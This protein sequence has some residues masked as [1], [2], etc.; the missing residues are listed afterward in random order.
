M[1]VNT[2]LRQVVLVR[3]CGQLRMYSPTSEPNREDG[4][5]DLVVRV[6]RDGLVS[7]WLDKVP[8]GG[9]VPMTWPWPPELRLDRRNPGRRVGL[10]AFGIGITEL[11]RTA[12]H[13]LRDPNV[14]EVVLLYATQV[15]E[16]QHVLGPELEEL[17]VLEPH[18]FRIERTLTRERIG[19]ARFGRVNVDMLA[20]V[21]PWHDDSRDCCRFASAGTRQMISDVH[22]ML[23]QLGYDA[24]TYEL[25]RTNT[26][27]ATFLGWGRS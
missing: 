25:I 13:E 4:T 18:R 24:G 23:R 2:A 7:Q 10:I 15:S 14:E 26:L 20:E 17:L 11:Y 3:A 22:A 9:S 6:Y 8:L 19:E 16:E 12:I 27:A 5:F 1:N 21:F